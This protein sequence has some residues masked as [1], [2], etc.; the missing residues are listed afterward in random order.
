MFLG[1]DWTQWLPAIT[2]AL[3]ALTVLVGIRS[4]Y[5]DHTKDGKLTR[6]GWSV[7]AAMVVLGILT[8]L[9]GLLDQRIAAEKERAEA[10]E[11]EE[12]FQRQMA[13]LRGL[14]T[15]MRES[16]GK[17]ERLFGVA[18]R[19]L[20]T[21]E[22]LQQQTQA[23]T[24][25]VLRRVFE[26]S[27]RLAAERVAVAVSYVC[28]RIDPYTDT[29]EVNAAVV[30]ART[31]SGLQIQLRTEQKVAINSQVIFHGFVGELG[32]FERFDTWRTARVDIG[33][34]ASAPITR[35]LNMDEFLAMT[36]EQRARRGQ[37]PPGYACPAMVT[38]ILNGREVARADGQIASWGPFYTA[39]FGNLRVDTRRLPRFSSGEPR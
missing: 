33:L 28:P 1:I 21:S 36:D 3:I 22:A 29:P 5:Q 17:Q 6:A 23:N 25:T 16:L 19:N 35:V 4:L 39:D 8:F 7:V 2:A 14:E 32:P 24:L 31:S 18:N 30:Y 15:G 12:R 10:A 9:S 13:S 26:E 11:R 38:L 20:N 34:G 27:N 37:V